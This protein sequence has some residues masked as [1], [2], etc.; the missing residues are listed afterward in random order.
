[1]SDAEFPRLLAFQFLEDINN[2]F[3]ATYGKRGQTAASFAFNADFQTT[4]DEQFRIYNQKDGDSE[5][6]HQVRNIP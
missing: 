6:L 4:L 3:L 1:M 5:K 2:R